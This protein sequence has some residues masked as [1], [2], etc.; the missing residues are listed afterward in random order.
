MAWWHYLLLVNIYLVLF[1]GFYALLLRKETFFQLNRI[2]LVSASL[3]SFFIPGIQSDWVKSL[4][5]T[6]QVHY[7]LY[8]SP[9]VTYQFT[10]VEQ[11]T[12]LTMGQILV[13][14]YIAG[15]IFLT[16]R[17][18]LQLI[19]IKKEIN[20]PAPSAAFSFFKKI[21]LGEN[22]AKQQAIAVHEQVHARQW[23]TL[24][25]LLIE[26]VMIINWFNPVVHLYRLAIKHIHEFIADQQAIKVSSDKAEYALLLLSQTFNTPSN[27][28]VN[29]FYNNSLLKQRI[30][31]IQKNKSHRVTLIKYGLSAP[32]FI[33]MLVLSSA[34]INNSKAI[35]AIHTKADHVFLQ[36]AAD[37]FTEITDN[38]KIPDELNEKP[39]TVVLKE[40]KKIDDDNKAKDTVKR[41]DPVAFSAVDAPPRFPGGV[42]SFY[43]F[44]RKNIR[45]PAIM[46]EKYIQGRVIIT[47]VVETDGSLSDIKAIRGPGY[48]SEEESIRV[49]SLSPRWIPGV[50][51]GKQ[52]RVQYTVPISFTLTSPVPNK[53]VG[54]S[55]LKKAWNHGVPVNQGPDST[56]RI[57]HRPLYI[58]DGVEMADI[59]QAHI[60]SAIQSVLVYMKDDPHA[61]AYGVKGANG[62]MIFTTRRGQDTSQISHT[63]PK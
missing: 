50:Q 48:G 13:Y 17:F 7:T 14:L 41:V 16:V 30:V 45:Y 44:L 36:P 12:E 40:S 5:I 4:F 63:T 54:D 42:E 6:E 52:V 22:L 61:K 3:L 9:V 11:H 59:R 47:F 34:T 49:I 32:L 15:I 10:P 21:S 62:V 18:I 24:D 56:W 51:N 58:V 26:A 37:A 33:L 25:V 29:S 27:K 57:A 39:V 43:M 35:N 20:N 1:F 8:S 38:A 53:P 60:T 31:M 46:R 2:Y 23:H 55:T 28:L 19:T